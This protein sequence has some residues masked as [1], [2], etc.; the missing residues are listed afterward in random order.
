MSAV[1]L[2]CLVLLCAVLSAV[3]GLQVKAGLNS[4]AVIG[5]TCAI[6]VL[7]FAIQSWGTQRVGVMFAP[8]VALWF[9]S[10]VLVWIYNICMFEGGLIF[11]ALS[12]HYIGACSCTT[13]RSRLEAGLAELLHFDIHSGACLCCNWCSHNVLA[14]SS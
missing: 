13:L 5:I 10:D 14:S 12:P 3:S 4:S 9:L 7:L 1:S 2:L 11:R 6:L 8:T